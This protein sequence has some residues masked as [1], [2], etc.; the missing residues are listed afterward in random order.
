MR[1][2]RHDA[3]DRQQIDELRQ[4]HAELK[5]AIDLAQAFADIVRYRQ[6]RKFDAWLTQAKASSVTTL[7]RFANSLESDYDAVKAALSLRW[8]NGPVEGFINKLKMLKR[9]MFGRANFDLL[10][11]R[12]LYA[13]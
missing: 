10:E 5:E 11:K 8:S 4:A 13:F 7:A 6:A 3:D 1:S 12:L 2:E 9:S